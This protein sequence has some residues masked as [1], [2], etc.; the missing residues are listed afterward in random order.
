MKT[1]GILTVQLHW[2]MWTADHGTVELQ[3]V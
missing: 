1:F 3:R 2:F